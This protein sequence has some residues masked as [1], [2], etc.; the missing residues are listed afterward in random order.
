MNHECLAELTGVSKRFG[1]VVALDALDLQIRAGELFALLGQNSA[2]KL[3]P[4]LCSSD[5]NNQ[6]PGQRFC[7]GGLRCRSRPGGELES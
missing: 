2:G 4:F 3:P 6:T 7:S 5:C 1:N